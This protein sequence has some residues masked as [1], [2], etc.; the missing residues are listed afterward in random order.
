MVFLLSIHSVSLSFKCLGGSVSKNKQQLQSHWNIVYSL[1]LWLLPMLHIQ[2]DIILKSLL[3]ASQPMIYIKSF[4]IRCV[5]AHNTSWQQ[6]LPSSIK[7][8]CYK[9]K[10]TYRSKDKQTE[11]HLKRCSL[12]TLQLN[13]IATN[14]KLKK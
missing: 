2:T 12:W 9:W 3:A 1:L 4:I 13:K 5:S 7:R 14:G 10:Q 6:Q 11:R 8:K